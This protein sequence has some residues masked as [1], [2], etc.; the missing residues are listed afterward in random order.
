LLAGP[1]R[2]LK[3]PLL[4]F[5]VLGAAVFGLDRLL[6]A[7]PQPAVGVIAVDAERKR[8]LAVRFEQR[9]GRPPG[10]V[11]LRRAVDDWIES[12]IL[13]REG[14]RIG[15]HH[16]DAAVRERVVERMRFVLA[17]ADPLD[18]APED[19][20]RA[21]FE[22]HRKLYERPARFDFAQVLVEGSEAAQRHQAEQ[23]LEQL[24]GGLAPETLGE[25]YREYDNRTRANVAAMY[26]AEFADALAEQAPRSWQLQQSPR[27]FHL[28]RLEG[29]RDT[30]GPSFESA[31]TQIE[32]D[33][34]AH[35]RRE[36][37]SQALSGLRKSYQVVGGGS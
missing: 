12:E 3:Q 1:R 13:Y 16:T 27:G 21:W 11:E 6:G 30:S 35:R 32:E 34:R 14:L 25:R 33:W 5:A 7:D 17:H 29:H 37:A 23:L 4:H 22:Q 26:G 2:W 8:E 31:R 9:W 18:Q 24:R 15:L 20:L 10:A 28:V 36:L 19:G